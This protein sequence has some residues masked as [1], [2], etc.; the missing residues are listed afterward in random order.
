MWTLNLNPSKLSEE[1]LGTYIEFVDNTIH[2]NLP[3][4][5][6]NP[7]LYELVNHYQTYKHSKSCRKYKNKLCRYGFGKFFTK[8]TIIAQPLE[9]G[10]KDVERYSILKKRDTILSKVIDF[11]NKYLDPSKNTYRKDLSTDGILMELQLTKKEYYW[12]L[13]ISSENDFKLHYQ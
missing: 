2:A 10:I 6:D 4:P 13:S 11:I 5:D 3:G 1:T 7:V 9:D 12:A 8:E